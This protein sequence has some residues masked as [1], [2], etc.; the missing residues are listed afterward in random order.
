[1]T[2]ARIDGH[3]IKGIYKPMLKRL[4]LYLI[5]YFGL[6]LSACGGSTKTDDV[7]ALREL[8][9]AYTNAWKLDGLDAQKAAV[10]PLFTDDAVILPSGGKFILSGTDD[11]HSFWFPEGAPVARTFVFDQTVEGVTVSGDV[12]TFHG[13]SV[14]EMEFDGRDVNQSATYLATARRAPNGDWQFS[15]LMWTDQPQNKSTKT[16]DAAAISEDRAAE[17]KQAAMDLF[18]YQLGRWDSRWDIYDGEGKIV[19]SFTGVEE[20]KPLVDDHSQ[21]LINNVPEQDQTTYAMLSYNEIEHKIIFLNA[22][23]R[24]DYWIMRQDPETG[25][26]I[27]EPHKNADGSEVIIKFSTLRQTADA[28]DVKMDISRDNGQTWQLVNKQYLTRKSDN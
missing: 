25:T 3:E 12:G 11:I 5:L 9:A 1:M 16:A 21:M 8:S 10:M 26:M 4:N 24:G 2:A 6:I 23:P 7:A 22:G 15:R 17:I 14:L 13:R 20:F 27:S 18:A 19:R 28:F